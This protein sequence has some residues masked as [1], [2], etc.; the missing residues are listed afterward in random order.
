VD[1][2]GTFSDPHIRLEA[3][4]LVARGAAAAVLSLASPL[5]SL[6]ALVDF[7][8]AEKDVCTAAVAHLRNAP[9]AALAP[10][11]AKP[12]AVKAPASAARTH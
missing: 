9:K 6:L 4:P 8:Q 2:T 3:K 12:K 1:V 5:A 7:K 10:S 11:A